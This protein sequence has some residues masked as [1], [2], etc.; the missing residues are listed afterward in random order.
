MVDD[1]RFCINIVI[2]SWDEA[3]PIF[4]AENLD[5][6]LGLDSAEAQEEFI[7]LTGFTSI[8]AA[9]KKQP[10][11]VPIGS[12]QGCSLDQQRLSLALTVPNF[13]PLLPLSATPLPCLSR[14][15]APSPPSDFSDNPPALHSGGPVIP[16]VPSV[17]EAECFLPSGS[18]NAGP[19][20]DHCQTLIKAPSLDLM[21]SGNL[22]A[23]RISPRLAVKNKGARKSSLKAQDL[24]CKKFKSVRFASKVDCSALSSA[25]SGSTLGRT[26]SSSKMNNISSSPPSAPLDDIFPVDISSSRP[27]ILSPLR[28]AETK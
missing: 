22:L 23:H 9:D 26:L 20:G 5:H 18:G 7:R 16:L 6:H 13:P 25:I 24:K 3:N 12:D 21:A 17:P 14:D 4:L 27:D 10:S 1:R 8:L 19:D 2:D 28:L 15:R 11:L